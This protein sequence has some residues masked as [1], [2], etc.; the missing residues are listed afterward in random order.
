[1][2]EPTYRIATREEFVERHMHAIKRFRPDEEVTP[3]QAGDIYDQMTG[4]DIGLAK[5]M[6]DR[7]KRPNFN[8]QKQKLGNVA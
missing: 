2:E 8:E 4:H 3:E 1:M 7:D 6:M 5:S